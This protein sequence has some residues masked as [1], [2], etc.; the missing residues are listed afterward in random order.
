M[1]VL[2]AT[3]NAFV[4]EAVEKIEEILTGAK[5]TVRKLEGYR[6]KEELLEAVAD[7]DAMIIRSDI[8]DKEVL[9]RASKMQLVVRAGAGYDNIDLAA[10][11]ESSVVVMNTPGQNANA[12]AELILA[13][14]L[15]SAR[16]NFDG[17]SGFEIANRAIG[18][19]GFGAVAQAVHKLARAFGMK[20]Y[21]YAPSLP[22][23]KIAEAGA[24][25]VNSLLD[26]FKHQYVSLHVPLTEETRDSINGALLSV[27]PDDGIL[28]NTARPEIVNQDDLLE[29]LRV[30]PN[31]GYLCDAAPRNVEEMKQAA[32]DRY[33]KRVLF[34]QQS[35]GGETIEAHINAGVEAA[36]R[37]VNFFE[38]GPA[39]LLRKMQ[40]FKSAA[41][42]A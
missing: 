39:A 2:I 26:L 5:Y 31:F 19:Y 40:E 11:R 15:V 13:M 1:T 16:N 29:T 42:N 21:A 34:T 24:T 27:M 33:M 9:E 30:R 18:L 12:V 35:M 32:G 23:E 8:I 22:A 28:I 37:T 25:P 41:S 10:C 20:S 17:T 3:R 38:K 4:K 14:M 7:V 6:C 36:N